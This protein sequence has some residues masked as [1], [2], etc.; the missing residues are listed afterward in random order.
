[1]SFA[2]KIGHRF[3]VGEASSF[4]EYQELLVWR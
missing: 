2:I 1:L 4:A 3:R